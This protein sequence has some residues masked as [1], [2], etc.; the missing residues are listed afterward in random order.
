MWGNF[1]TDRIL[2]TT[3]AGQFCQ[4]LLGAVIFAIGAGVACA[5]AP[6]SAP[7]ATPQSDPAFDASKRAFDALAEADR[8]AIQDG[9][10]WTGDYKGNVDGGFGRGTRAAII[11]FAQRSGLPTDGTLDARGRGM[12]IAAAVQARSAAGFAP[13]RDPRTGITLGLP[14]KL[15]PR[16]VDTP[17]GS[18]WS[19]SDGSMVVDT[20]QYPPGDL[21]PLFDQ[22]KDGGP[23]RKVT[24]KILRPDF[25]VVSGEAGKSVF[26]SRIA[27]APG[28]PPAQL[29]GYTITYAAGS[30]SLDSISIAVANTFVPFAPAGAVTAQ[31]NQTA[32]PA[33]P[34]TGAAPGPAARPIL[35]ATG[36]VVAADKVLTLA[37]ACKSAQVSGRPAT[38]AK[39]DDATGL[40]LLQVA[41]LNGHPL[42]LHSVNA[43]GGSPAVVV[44]EALTSATGTVIE[45][46]VAT[47]EILSPVGTGRS[48]VLAPIQAQGQGGPIF[49]RS[50][51]LIGVTGRLDSVRQ[52]AG[53][54]PQT[55]RPYVPAAVVASFLGSAGLAAPT[56]T[57]ADEKVHRSAAVIAAEAKSA[58]VP[59]I[60]IP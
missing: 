19:A 13:T 54:V 41:G 27:R 7:T 20:V 47:G 34:G 60:C 33:G 15:L 37:G 31:G 2:T 35:T 10:I 57:T 32:A 51:A 49:D 38:V 40:T 30:K 45:M 59:V 44:F 18:R 55:A 39:A 53:V 24:Y 58:I 1:V 12:L 36:I 11:A 23:G 4:V 3:A 56:G 50:G 6:A 8:R 46:Q 42:A 28:D 48:R 14:L 26:Y 17:Q 43:E 21:P 52:V 29:R 25:L 16:R 22:L 9:L 5:Q